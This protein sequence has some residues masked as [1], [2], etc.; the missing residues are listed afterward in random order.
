M[1]SPTAAQSSL[2]HCRTL[3]SFMVA[4]STGQTSTT[5]RSQITMPPEWMPRW[6]GKRWT[7]RASSM[8][9]EG[10]SCSTVAST[11]PQASTCLDQASSWPGAY[12]RAAHVTHGRARLVGD[13]V[14]DL[15]G[16]VAAVTLVDVLDDLLA[17]AGLDVQVDVGR[18]VAL[19]GQEPLEQQAEET[20]SALVIP[21]A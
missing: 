16:P 14:G 19:R 13:H 15:G 2:S 10:M 12:P 8:T 20:A 18:P 7:W 17:A 5:G 3:R 1:T 21:I 9:W 6:R 11:G 4:H